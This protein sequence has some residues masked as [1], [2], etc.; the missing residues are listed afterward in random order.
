MQLLF[1]APTFDARAWLPALE[2]ALPEARVR[3]W[4]AGDDAAAD[5]ALVWRPAAAMLQARPGLK[6][7]FLLGA[8]ADGML[9]DATAL[10]PELPIVRL[11]DAGMAVQMAEYA[12]H[13]VLR[14]YRRFD[15]YERQQRAGVW[16]RLPLR[17]KRDFAVGIMGL[18]VLGIAI[19]AALSVFEFPLRGWSRSQTEITDI[20]CFSGPEELDAF[21]SR[22]RVLICALPLTDETKNLINRR[23]LERLPRGAYV[24][25]LARGAHLVEEDLL[26]LLHSG[27]LAGATLDVFQEEPLPADH[28]FWRERNITLT[29][30]ISALTLVEESVAQIVSKINALEQGLPITGIV[31]RSKGY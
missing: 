12:A 25:N 10:P 17:D 21:L 15:E 24:I 20:Q 7:V 3:I 31:D 2:R 16:Q 6:A 11:E 1:H 4:Q 27:H 14:H 28:P 13:A 26:A 5:Y 8:G 22:T 9:A 23:L 30:H 29:P 19:A 18:G